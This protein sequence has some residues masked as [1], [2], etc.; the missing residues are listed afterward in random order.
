[1]SLKQRISTLFG[2]IFKS[3]LYWLAIAIIL[4]TLMVGMFMQY[5]VTNGLK[6]KNTTT[7]E[8]IVNK[9]TVDNTII[10]T[11]KMSILPETLRKQFEV[12]AT[13]KHSSPK[14]IEISIEDLAKTQKNLKCDLNTQSSNGC[15]YTAYVTNAG[16]KCVCDSYDD[17]ND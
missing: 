3:K 2:Y 17:F 11:E 15:L 13:F 12:Y 1:M 10:S 9:A 14:I 16:L 8:I 4:L 7:T 5:E 6:I